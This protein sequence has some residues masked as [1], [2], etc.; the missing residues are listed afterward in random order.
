[1]NDWI[2]QLDAAL[3]RRRPE[4]YRRLQPGV[5]ARALDDFQARF[6]LVLP[7]LFRRLYQW[8]DGQDPDETANLVGNWMFKPLDDV[9]ATKELLD[10]MIGTDFEDPRWWSRGWVPFLHNGGGDLLCLD[11]TAEFGGVPGQVIWFWHDEATRPVQF[12]SLEAWLRAAVE[13][14]GGAR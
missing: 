8:R 11:V 5:T 12:D 14:V 4:Y 6:G 1:M 2:D 10:D 9:T 7:P 13:E 3:A